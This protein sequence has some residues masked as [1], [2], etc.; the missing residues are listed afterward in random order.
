MIKNRRKV[1]LGTYLFLFFLTFQIFAQAPAWENDHYYDLFKLDTYHSTAL[2]NSETTTINIYIDAYQAALRFIVFDDLSEEE[3]QK[4]INNAIA[5]IEKAP[6]P[7]HL[8]LYY[9]IDLL[10]LSAHLELKKG[11]ELKFMWMMDNV[12]KK[13]QHLI[14]KWPEFL[15]GKKVAGT[16]L[17]MIGSV[18]DQYQWVMNLL[19]YNGDSRKG[20]AYLETLN[21]ASLPVKYE[22]LLLSALLKK[23]LTIED[24]SNSLEQLENVISENPEFTLMRLITA[25]SYLKQHQSSKAHDH[26]LKIKNFNSPL[27][28]Y[29]LGETYL[30]QGNHSKAVQHYQDFISRSRGNNLIKDSYSKIYISHYITGNN[31]LAKK[32]KALALNSGEA[33][34]EADKNAQQLL[35]ETYPAHPAIFQIRYYTDGGYYQKALQLSDSAASFALNTKDEIELNYRLAR[36]RHLTGDVNEA[37]KLYRKSIKK[38][39]GRYFAPNA[40][41][42][43][44]LIYIGENEPKQAKSYF[45]KVLEYKNY[46]YENS[47]KGKARRALK[48]LKQ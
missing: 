22:T 19:G 5:F 3:V 38:D 37:I 6:L 34:T 15:P 45:E 36:I 16:L 21:K 29:L 14:N 44:G 40:A 2:T 9:R 10:M 30:H 42:Q 11:N 39:D 25:L 24:S 33:N 27:I 20:V 7:E 23:Y 46:T 48:N 35:N 1:S 18:P 8:S 26:L 17:I 12:Y 31:A 28:S 13:S 32:F 47:I 4:K 43:L 41:L